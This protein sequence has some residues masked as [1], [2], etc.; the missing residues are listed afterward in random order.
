MGQKLNSM[1]SWKQQLSKYVG[2]GIC[3]G[4]YFC[5]WPLA[6]FCS[7]VCVGPGRKPERLFSHDA[8]QMVLSLGRVKKHNL[9]TLLKKK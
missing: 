3:E 6:I 8:A 7:L 2:G 9:Y 5:G 1:Y 4:I